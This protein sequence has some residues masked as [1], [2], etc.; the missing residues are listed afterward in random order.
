MKI[1]LLP[2][3]RSI[4]ILGSRSEAQRH[5]T[6]EKL[7]FP[8]VRFSHIKSENKKTMIFFVPVR[9]IANIIKICLFSNN[10]ISKSLRWNFTV[11]VLIESEF[12][13]EW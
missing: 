10:D 4:H 6:R 1:F 5:F 12:F 7:S 9:E 11:L 13:A 3:F 2:A 8:T